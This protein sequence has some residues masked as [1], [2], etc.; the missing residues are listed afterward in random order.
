MPVFVAF[1]ALMFGAIEF[2][3]GF[4]CMALGFIEVAIPIG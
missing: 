2:F 4:S 3:F 1:V